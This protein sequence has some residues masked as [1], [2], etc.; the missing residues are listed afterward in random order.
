MLV[1]PRTRC[2]SRRHRVQRIGY[3]YSAHRPESAPRP[4][5]N[6]SLRWPATAR[7]YTAND[8]SDSFSDD[9]RRCSGRLAGYRGTPSI[10]C[11]DEAPIPCRPPH[12]VYRSRSWERPLVVAE[13][14]SRTDKLDGVIKHRSSRETTMVRHGASLHGHLLLGGTDG[15]NPLPSS[16]ESAANLSSRR[17]SGRNR[18]PR[19][20]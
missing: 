3:T 1:R 18:L 19:A 16:K 8:R 15:S 6:V 13:G 5:G 12:S 20:R 9:A 7:I 17:R 2:A 10:K 11:S 14:R 4:S